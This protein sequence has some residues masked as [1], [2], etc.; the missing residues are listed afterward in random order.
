MEGSMVDFRDYLYYDES[1]PSCLRWGK[2][3]R[4]A[5]IKDKAAGSLDKTTGY[6]RVCVNGKLFYAHRV[7]WCIH[8]LEIECTQQ[9][10]HINGIKTDN[11]I[12]N[13]RLATQAENN[14]NQKLRRNNKSGVTGV[15]FGGISWT[16]GW[17]SID[18]KRR[19]KSFSI[20]KYGN[21]LAFSMACEYRSKIIDELNAAGGGYTERHGKKCD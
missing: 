14:R 6:Y 7:V 11:R 10:D 8:N 19:T 4:G 12:V 21:D 5:T 2:Y 3:I 20:L 18:N 1:S 17:R 13:L 15:S 16:V 9:I